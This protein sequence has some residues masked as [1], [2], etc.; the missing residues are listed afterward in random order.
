MKS[1]AAAILAASSTCCQRR[2]GMAEGDVG[3]DRV[4]EQER[5]L[6]HQADVPPQVVEV[7]VAQV[8][9]VEQNP[10]AGRIVKA[11]EQGQERLLPAP[12]APRIATFWPG[13]IDEGHVL[14]HRDCRACIRTRRGRI[15]C[16]PA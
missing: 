5:L 14:E 2:L 10:A 12:V 7:E 15:R 16:G 6:K 4:A 8:V 3:G 13:S 9:A 1:W 11:A